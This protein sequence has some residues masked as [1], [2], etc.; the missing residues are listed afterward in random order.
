MFLSINNPL[1]RHGKTEYL[2]PINC[3]YQTL[4]PFV[5]CFLLGSFLHRSSNKD[6]FLEIIFYGIGQF[7]FEPVKEII[8]CIYSIASKFSQVHKKKKVFLHPKGHLNL[9]L[10]DYVCALTIIWSS[11]EFL[12]AAFPILKSHAHII[13]SFVFY[14]I[15]SCLMHFAFIT[16]KRKGGDESFWSIMAEFMQ[17]SW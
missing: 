13:F 17:C 8:V 11:K 6:A 12:I 10:T 15:A 4:K 3:R 14:F 7:L 9:L 1:F 16:G 2:L 5:C